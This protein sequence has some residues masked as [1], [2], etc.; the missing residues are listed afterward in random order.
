MNRHL[1]WAAALAFPL[2]GL[3]YSWL[4]T[5][6]LAQQGEEWLIPVEGYDPRDLLRGHF[7]QY[8]YDWPDGKPPQRPMAAADSGD[9]PGAEAYTGPD[10]EDA[11]SICIEGKAPNMTLASVY[12]DDA[13]IYEND[14]VAKPPKKCAIIARA[15]LGTR[16]EVQGLRSG[17]IYVSQDQ[18]RALEAKL[19]D[20]KLQG[21]IRVN[22][23]ED[24]VMRPV[25]ME[26]RP[27]PAP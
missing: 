2:I 11:S 4:S 22:I 10:I 25:K 12:E 24:G 8:Q 21:L 20:P 18:G 13:R 9:E 5:H 26:F 1:L 23:R 15:T 19:A 6:Q 14:A 3:G 7:V 27:R 17:I 16:Q